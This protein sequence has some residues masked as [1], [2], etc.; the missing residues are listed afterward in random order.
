MEFHLKDLFAI[1]ISIITRS[2]KSV[3]EIS[4]AGDISSQEV[5]LSKILFKEMY[6]SDIE[7][8]IL[9][10]MDKSED[11]NL[12]IIGDEN[13]KE[14]R[15]IKGISF[16]EIFVDTLSLPFV[17]YIFASSNK[18]ALEGFEQNLEGIQTKFYNK[19]EEE[20][21]DE[22]I[23]TASLEYIR[24]NIS[25]FVLK[26]DEQDREGIEQILRL[27]YFLGIVKNIVEVKFF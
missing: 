3:F 7:I 15:F 16:S 1:H 11:K 23:S 18:E 22:N 17:N 19:I 9:T 6:G 27:P 8:E 26:F 12:L 5:I 10:S 24:S 13:F 4:L 2:K 14:E 25:S 21:F 20:K